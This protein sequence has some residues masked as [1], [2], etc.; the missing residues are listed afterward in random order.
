MWQTVFPHQRNACL[1]QNQ[2][3]IHNVT[4]LLT[5]DALKGFFFFCLSFCSQSGKNDPADS[6]NKSET[7]TTHLP[8]IFCYFALI[9]TVC[10]ILVVMD[11]SGQATRNTHSISKV[12]WSSNYSLTMCEQSQTSHSPL[13]VCLRVA[14][15]VVC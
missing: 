9:Y 14:C 15:E 2:W 4:P 11:V 3:L 8:L 5:K 10:F 13:S 6:C 7:A 12:Q 1:S